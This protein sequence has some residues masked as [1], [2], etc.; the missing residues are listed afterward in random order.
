M[1]GDVVHL[2]MQHDLVT[3]GASVRL[4]SQDLRTERLPLRGAVPA[5]GGVVGALVFAR[6]AMRATAALGGELGAARH[7]AEMGGT[8]RHHFLWRVKVRFR[9]TAIDSMATATIAMTHATRGCF[10]RKR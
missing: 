8:I 1:L 7:D 3:V 6:H 9:H 5:A 4:L 10:S 2:E